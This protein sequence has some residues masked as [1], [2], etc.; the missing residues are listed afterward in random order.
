ME[1]TEPEP[2]PTIKSLLKQ[3]SSY[4]YNYILT[5]EQFKECR[6][7]PFTEEKLI[8]IINVVDYFYET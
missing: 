4:P 7:E 6:E 1:E 8:R 3:L 5:P 2:E